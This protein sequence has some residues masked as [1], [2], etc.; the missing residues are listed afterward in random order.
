V[1]YSVEVDRRKAIALAISEARAGDIVLLAGKGHEKVQ[2][3]RDGVAPFDDLEVARDAL[4]AAG[5]ECETA[6]MGA[7][8]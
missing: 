7:K 3:T 2:V 6:H 5:F 1:K 4:R 8:A